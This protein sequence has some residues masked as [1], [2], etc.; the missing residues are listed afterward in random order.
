VAFPGQTVAVGVIPGRATVEE[1][2]VLLVTADTIDRH[3]RTKAH[4]H[5]REHTKQL[6]RTPAPQR[7]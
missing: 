1:M 5:A 3:T 7:D 2:T 4:R 6:H